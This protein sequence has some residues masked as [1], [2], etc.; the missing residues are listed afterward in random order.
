MARLI[1]TLLAVAL[2]GVCNAIADTLAHHFSTSV[3]KTL[4]P[5]FWDAAVSWQYATYLPLT[6][7]KI[8]AWHL[9]SSFEVCMWCMAVLLA[10][11]RSD[12]YRSL[13]LFN[14]LLYIG[15]GG[16]YNLSF[17]LFYNTLLR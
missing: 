15:L 12:K 7:Y 13:F 4:D 6:K 3:F 16:L 10:G 11:T 14:V 2:A 17:N 8:D 5:K 1:L 9:F